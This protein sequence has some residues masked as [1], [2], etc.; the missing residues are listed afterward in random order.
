MNT[1]ALTTS[2]TLM[3]AAFSTAA[4]FSSTVVVCL[5]MSP[6]N[7]VLSLPLRLISPDMNSVLPLLM[8]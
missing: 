5:V 1:R 3:P 4:P 2:S 6:F 7:A 8:P